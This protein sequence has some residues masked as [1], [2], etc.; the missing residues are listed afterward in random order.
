M[1]VEEG[2]GSL[3]TGE[4]EKGESQA[5]VRARCQGRQTEVGTVLIL[6]ADERR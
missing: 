5:T 3:D 6:P 4:N 1:G 2:G